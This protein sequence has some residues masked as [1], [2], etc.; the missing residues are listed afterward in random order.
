MN[1]LRTL[2]DLDVAFDAVTT[3]QELYALT[4]LVSKSGSF[5]DAF[6]VRYIDELIDAVRQRLGPATPVTR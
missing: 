4:E 2:D 3:R 1:N 6:S 5:I